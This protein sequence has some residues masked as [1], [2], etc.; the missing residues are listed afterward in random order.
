M[1][2]GRTNVST[3][4]LVYGRNERVNAAMKSFLRALGLQVVEFPQAAPG[5][6][7]TAFIGETVDRAIREASAVVVLFTPDEEVAIRQELSKAPE[8]GYQARPNVY[9]E[10]GLAMATRRPNVVFVEVGEV[11]PFS[12][13][14]GR[15]LVRFD[16][17]PRSRSALASRLQKAG[18]RVRN[19]GE[20]WKTAGD[21]VPVVKP[22]KGRSSR[23]T[24]PKHPAAA[25]TEELYT[26]ISGGLPGT[27]Y[28]NVRYTLH[29]LPDYSVRATVEFTLGSKVEDVFCITRT[30]GG[31]PA[32]VGQLKLR[33]TAPRGTRLLPLLA[34]DEPTTKRFLL[35]TVPK[36]PKGG[37]RRCAIEVQW[38]NAGAK[39]RKV[40]GRPNPGAV[41][42]N[43]FQVWENGRGVA[44]RV[45]VRIVFSLPGVFEIRTVFPGKDGT[46]GTWKGPFSRARPY[47]YKALKVALGT[48]LRFDVRRTEK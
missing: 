27:G 16:G 47:S 2:R 22:L 5:L 32:D 42:Q 9:F 35:F 10:A 38:P 41:D 3:V 39:L 21:F 4:F 48:N 45:T 12:D 30:L 34:H 19:D 25:D 28:S 26:A 37:S 7:P 18:C 6:E 43:S 14:A 44:D 40:A 8:R 15:W 23:A 31:P 1:P 46:P 24:P 17:G 33:T 29:Y 20:D 36:I 11:R 13:T